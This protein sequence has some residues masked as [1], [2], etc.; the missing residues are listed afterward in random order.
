MVRRFRFDR[1]QVLQQKFHK[2]FRWIGSRHGPYGVLYIS[3]TSN[4]R[5]RSLGWL[6]IH[7]CYLLLLCTT[8]L[9]GL[10][11]SYHFLSNIHARNT[12]NAITK[13]AMVIEAI[14]VMEGLSVLSILRSPSK[15]NT[16]SE[17]DMLTQQP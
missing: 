16:N 4:T 14:M 8:H 13:I 10:V 15:P 6:R 5:N 3:R 11:C 17:L 2:L 9:L 7:A 1:V 12:T